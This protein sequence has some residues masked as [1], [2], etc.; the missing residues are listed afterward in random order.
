M[1]EQKKRVTPPI[2]GKMYALSVHMKYG[3]VLH[4][5]GVNK[6]EK[7]NYIALC[8]QSD[9]EMIIEDKFE[10]RHLLS[11]DIAKVSV[12]PYDKSYERVWHPLKKMVLSESTVRRS[13][14]SALIKAFFLLALVAVVAVLGMKVIDGTILDVFFDASLFAQTLEE[15]MDY[16]GLIFKY[17]F[18]LMVILGILDMLLGLKNN[19][20]INQDG[21]NEIDQSILGNIIVIAIFG[22]ACLI[23]SGIIGRMLLML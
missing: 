21:A 17:L 8:K 10:V 9:G 11:Q 14:F 5:E 6:E 7:D 12:V 4:I 3:E 13:T 22:V 15:V 16:I 20:P 23:A 18:F 1:S 19:F 2:S